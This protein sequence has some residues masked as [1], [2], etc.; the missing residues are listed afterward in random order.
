MTQ[1]VF[2]RPYRTSRSR[3]KGV[4]LK[5]GSKKGK[6]FAAI[7]IESRC[8]HLGTFDTEEQAAWAYDKA[9]LEHFGPQAYLNFRDGG[10]G[11]ETC[12]EENI[13]RIGTLRGEVFIIDME[14]AERVSKYDWTLNGGLITARIDGRS[15][16]L[17]EFLLGKVK[18]NTFIHLNADRRNYRRANLAIVP[19]TLHSGRH[20]KMAGTISRFKGLKKKGSK[21]QARIRSRGT[22]YYLGSFS[23][24]EEAARAFDRA[25]RRI[26]GFCAAVNLPEE[27]EIGCRAA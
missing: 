15:V 2:L 27:G 8:T 19:Y 21:W 24:E 14:D 16:Y 6:W 7:Y 1:T 9:A 10:K 11:I 17:H 23:E 13:A 3:F 26:Y 20:R 25:A 18:P 12:P 4:G 22:E 5:K